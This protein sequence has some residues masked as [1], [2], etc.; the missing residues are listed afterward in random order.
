M[1]KIYI[2]VRYFFRN[3]VQGVKN[4]WRWFPVIWKDR[5]WDDAFILDVLKFKLKNT[6]DELE[7]AAF[8]TGYEHEVSRIRLCVKLIE[9]VQEEYY[10]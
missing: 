4:L 8:F 5:D 7:R 1:K 3:M 9:L 6:A 10:A 2:E